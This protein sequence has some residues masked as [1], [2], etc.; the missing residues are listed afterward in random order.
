[1]KNQQNYVTI[2]RYCII[3]G[4]NLRIEIKK[5]C[6]ISRKKSTTSSR[7]TR[8][9]NKK[10]DVIFLGKNQLNPQRDFG[11]KI[12]RTVLYFLGKNPLHPQERLVCKIKN[13]KLKRFKQ[14]QKKKRDNLL[15]SINKTSQKIKKT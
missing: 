13:I 3:H 12:K 11:I 2:Q 8:C 4:K 5:Q 7:K 15:A 14:R 10:D 9:K 1:M 6:Y